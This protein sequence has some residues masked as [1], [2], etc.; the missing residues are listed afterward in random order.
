MSVANGL[1]KL[2]VWK[3]PKH[4]MEKGDF[5]VCKAL[6]G[7]RRPEGRSEA[8]LV[9]RMGTQRVRVGRIMYLIVTEEDYSW[10]TPLQQLTGHMGFIL[11]FP[12]LYCMPLQP[13]PSL[14]S[15]ASPA[16]ISPFLAMQVAMSTRRV[17]S[18]LCLTWPQSVV[19]QLVFSS[20]SS[21][22]CM[23]SVVSG[24]SRT[25]R[26]GFRKSLHAYV[27]IT[28]DGS[29]A[30]PRNRRQGEEQVAESVPLQQSELRRSLISMKHKPSDIA[31]C[32]VLAL[33]IELSLL[34]PLYLLS[35]ISPL[36]DSQTP[37]DI[38]MPL[39]SNPHTEGAFE[40]ARADKLG[41]TWPLRL[42]CAGFRPLL[43]KKAIN[44]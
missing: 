24:I 39:S 11:A 13:R 31:D 30:E 37:S 44:V 3:G 9:R 38:T 29:L 43:A 40:I 22:L 10:T 21:I 41:R 5:A 25:R 26:P 16:C 14:P 19:R 35:F 2:D 4:S 36:V 20:R 8:D 17:G 6:R 27:Y 23:A 34:H 12:S 32:H 28:D 1:E 42:D 15:P 7:K 18:A 33:C